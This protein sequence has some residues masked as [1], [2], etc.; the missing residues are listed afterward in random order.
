MKRREFLKA[1]VLTAGAAATLDRAGNAF[2]E[3]TGEEVTQDLASSSSEV[4]LAPHIM[5]PSMPVIHDPE[6]CIGCNTCVDVCH[7]GIMVPNPEKGKPPIIVWPEECW[8]CGLCVQFCPL[9]LEAKAITQ[10][11][12]INQRVR[13]KRKATGVHFRLGM[14]DPPAPNMTPPVGGWKAQS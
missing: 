10:N 1:S 4:R 5:T 8:P 7:Q 11:H 6:V 3:P 14:P 12:P 9:G 13:W 2:E